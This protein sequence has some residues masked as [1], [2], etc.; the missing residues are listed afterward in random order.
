MKIFNMKD[1]VSEDNPILRKAAEPVTLP[2]SQDDLETLQ[3]MAAFV[4]QSQ[5]KEI[6]DDG[7]LYT[8]AVGLAAPQVGISKQMFVIS[9]P[10][11]NNDLFTMAVV[12][13][14]IVT[15]NKEFISLSEGES[16]LSVK[17]LASGKVARYKKI[18]YDG[19]LVDLS[20]GEVEKKKMGRLEDYLAIVFQHEYDHLAGILYTD[21]LDNEEKNS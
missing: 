8:S 15:T 3:G 7:T 17:S 14:K 18:R 9:M 21:L 2:L 6:D 12:N 19:Y 5:T 10:D 13:P 4:M 11:D 20:T 1:L 16:C